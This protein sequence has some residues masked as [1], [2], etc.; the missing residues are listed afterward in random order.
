MGDGDLS[1][2]IVTGRVTIQKVLLEEK[3]LLWKLL[4]EYLSLEP[5]RGQHHFKDEAGEWK[6]PYFDLYWE[7]ETRHPFFIY[8]DNELA[9]FV[10]VRELIP[11]ELCS[12]VELYI[13]KQFWRKS[14]G[15]ETMRQIL[16]LF[17][18]KKWKISYLKE[19]AAQAGAF[20]KDW[21]KNNDLEVELEETEE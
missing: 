17:P 21:V 15:R 14:I 13:F 16:Q 4:Q 19:K 3:R 8:Y 9:G 1:A 7:K 2:D 18:Y 5:F 10:M 11:G 6:Y 12:I 20:W